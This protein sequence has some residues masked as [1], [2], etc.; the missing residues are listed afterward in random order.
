MKEY[1]P[2]QVDLEVE[3]VMR[4]QKNPQHFNLRTNRSW[5][6]ISD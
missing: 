3:K 4:Q 6:I 1:S 2:E 5:K